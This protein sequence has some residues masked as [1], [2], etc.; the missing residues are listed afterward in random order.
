LDKSHGLSGGHHGLGRP[1]G[2]GEKS[3]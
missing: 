1:G 2:F 3:E